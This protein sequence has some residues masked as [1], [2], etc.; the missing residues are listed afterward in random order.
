MNR[1]PQYSAKNRIRSV[2]AVLQEVLIFMCNIAVGYILVSII[3]LAIA[4]QS[5]TL[6]SCNIRVPHGLLAHFDPTFLVGDRPSPVLS[7]AL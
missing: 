1:L 7:V 3:V 4:P 2:S 5:I 6:G